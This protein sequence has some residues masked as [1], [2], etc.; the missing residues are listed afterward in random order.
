[1]VR[2][3]VAMPGNGLTLVVLRELAV[4]VAAPISAGITG[5]P[6]LAGK[7]LGLLAGLTADRTLVGHLA[8]HHGLEMPTEA[9][10]GIL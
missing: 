8:D 6:N 4:F 5:F 1:M 7:R 3:D 2:P 10:T 9:A